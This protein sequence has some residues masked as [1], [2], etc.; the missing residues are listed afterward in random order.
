[1]LA[2]YRYIELNPKRAGMVR[3]PRDYR[4]SSYQSNALGKVNNLL[5]PHEQYLRLGNDEAERRKNYRE[6]FKAHI[7]PETLDQI[8]S[9]TNG[10]Y[11]LGEARFQQEIEKI[12]G[13][14]TTRGQAGR[15][16]NETTLASERG[17]ALRA[18]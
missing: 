11:V 10:N 14:R 8:H 12:L 5:T 15:P 1:M 3:H 16:K 6:L 4:W 13:R 9:A 17:L 2:C 18:G 7:D